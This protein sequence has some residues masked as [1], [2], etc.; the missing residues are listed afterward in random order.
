MNTHDLSWTITPAAVRAAQIVFNAVAHIKSADGRHGEQIMSVM[1]DGLS[2]GVSEALTVA[3]Y[4]EADT[5][6]H[7]QGVARLAFAAELDRLRIASA[8]T[9]GRA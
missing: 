5:I 7:C 2:E 6:E 4:S 1:V 8:G 3:G 9:E